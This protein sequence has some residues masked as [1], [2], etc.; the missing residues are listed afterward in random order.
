[1]DILVNVFDLTTDG[2]KFYQHTATLTKTSVMGLEGGGVNHRN[3]T[4]LEGYQN[5]EKFIIFLVNIK[6]SP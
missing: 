1:M 6:I 4:I 5:I 3:I 2:K